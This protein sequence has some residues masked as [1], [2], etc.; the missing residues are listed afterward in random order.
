MGWAMVGLGWLGVLSSLRLAR[1]PQAN[2]AQKENAPVVSALTILYVALAVF[3]LYT[4]TSHAQ[5]IKSNVLF[6][7]LFIFYTAALSRAWALIGVEPTER[8]A[9][10]KSTA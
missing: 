6:A 9:H 10:A 7:I 4:A 3:G 2:A 8:P 5:H 1:A